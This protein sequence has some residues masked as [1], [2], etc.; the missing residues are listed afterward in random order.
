VQP[1]L[2]C[3]SGWLA[4]YII[5]DPIFHLYD[6]NN[7]LQS[8]A[9]YTP[10][11]YQVVEL[12]FFLALVFCAQRIL[13][14]FIGKIHPALAPRPLTRVQRSRSIASRSRSA[15]TQWRRRCA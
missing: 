1:V 8:R 9:S 5:F 11:V 14:H 10:R 7:E 12:I 15:R 6:A 13:F 4:W 2:Y 3:A